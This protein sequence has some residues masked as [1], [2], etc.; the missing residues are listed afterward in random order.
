M[1]YAVLN[2]EITIQEKFSGK[3]IKVP[4][5]SIYVVGRDG[6]MVWGRSADEMC[7]QPELL[8]TQPEARQVFTKPT[9]SLGQAVEQSI[10]I[11]EALFA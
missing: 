8:L 9:K 2:Q 10:S 4:A 11:C 6:Q 1:W 3:Y 7:Y 5:G